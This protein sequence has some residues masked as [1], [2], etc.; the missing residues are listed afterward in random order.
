MTDDAHA[1]GPAQS[2]EADD[3]LPVNRLTRSEIRELRNLLE[4][5]RR[6]KWF[7]STGRIWVAWLAG[8]IVATYSLYDTLEKFLKRIFGH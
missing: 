6:M 4:S 3:G 7:W 1:Q 8:T 5:E 2:G